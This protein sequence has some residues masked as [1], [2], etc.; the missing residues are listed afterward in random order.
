MHETL[1]ALAT[2][3]YSSFL[4]CLSRLASPLHVNY[5]QLGIYGKEGES[6]SVMYTHT[7]FVAIELL[8][9]NS[10]SMYVYYICFLSWRTLLLLYF[11]AINVYVGHCMYE[12]GK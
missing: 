2:V 9:F 4:L 6:G 5:F 8:T 11:V 1:L 12:W 10:S 3:Q 7:P